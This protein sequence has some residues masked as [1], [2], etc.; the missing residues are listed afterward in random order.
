MTPRLPRTERSMRQRRLPAAALALL[1]AMLAASPGAVRGDLD[2]LCEAGAKQGFSNIAADN[3]D[4]PLITGDGCGVSA[5]LTVCHVR[6][7]GGLCGDDA[8]CT[9]DGTTTDID[10]SCAVDGSTERGV[11]CVK[12]FRRPCDTCGP[13]VFRCG[14]FCATS[15]G[16]NPLGLPDDAAADYDEDGVGDVDSAADP[17][18]GTVSD[19]GT[20]AAAGCGMDWGWAVVA[21]SMLSVARVV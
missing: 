12:L 10:E 9:A 17:D 15:E 7:I 6:G 14:Q 13:E 8:E 2:A 3:E 5:A 19:S 4:N 20:S 21:V 1:V 16:G 18:G 11:C